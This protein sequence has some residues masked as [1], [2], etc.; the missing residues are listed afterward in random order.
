MNIDDIIRETTTDA[1]PEPEQP[2]Q[3]EESSTKKK[4]RLLSEKQLAVLQRG[5]EK[6]WKNLK[7][8]TPAEQTPAPVSTIHPFL[9]PR[10]SESSSDSADDSE[11]QDDERYPEP[12][13]TQRK[14]RIPKAVKRRVDRYIRERLDLL[15]SVPVH[16]PYPSTGNHDTR[17][18]SAYTHSSISSMPVQ[19]L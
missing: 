11:S 17:T 10:S 14:P 18:P 8:E 3:S 19:Y 5:R 4:R 1:V 6:R 2:Q 9:D 16:T 13:Q 15:N 12:S 7:S